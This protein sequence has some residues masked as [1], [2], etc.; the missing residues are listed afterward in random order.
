[1]DFGLQTLISVLL[2]CTIKKYKLIFME[3]VEPWLERLN[4]TSLTR[5]HLLSISLDTI[6]F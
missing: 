1:M 5:I 6:K 2:P 4:Y 3:A